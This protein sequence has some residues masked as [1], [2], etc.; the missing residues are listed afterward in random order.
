MTMSIQFKSEK[1][2]NEFSIFPEAKK[3][4][5]TETGGKPIFVNKD[6]EFKDEHGRKVMKGLFSSLKATSNDI[7]LIK[8]LNMVADMEI[9]EP[10]DTL[11][12][13]NRRVWS[14]NSFYS[15]N[16]LIRYVKRI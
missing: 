14:L 6:E 9:E 7:E 2:N 1:E 3:I 4:V 15:K 8:P 13:E 16:C 10:S 12:E 5:K 11:E